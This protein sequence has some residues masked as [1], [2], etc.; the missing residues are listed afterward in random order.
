MSKNDIKEKLNNKN[1]ENDKKLNLNLKKSQ[2]SIKSMGENSTSTNLC[3]KGTNYFTEKQSRIEQLSHLNLFENLENKTDDIKNNN[4]KSKEY[5]YTYKTGKVY[6]NTFYSSNNNIPLQ[7]ISN[8]STNILSPRLECQ[9]LND[10]KIRIQKNKSLNNINNK[11][12]FL[13]FSKD[14]S[15][16]LSIQDSKNKNVIIYEKDNKNLYKKNKKK[17]LEISSGV[18]EEIFDD[19]YLKNNYYSKILSSQISLQS[20]SDSKLCQIANYYITTDESFE[21]FM[22]ERKNI[23]NQ[24]IL[25]KKNFSKK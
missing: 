12:I 15:K 19:N 5:F 6:Y 14:E 10:N 2:K 22:I 1:E 24:K 23:N 18:I 21:K 17:N 11:N 3:E 20:I 16:K 4:K 7:S 9:N 25:K 8:K 13:D